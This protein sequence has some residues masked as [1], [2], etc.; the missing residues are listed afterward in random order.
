MTPTIAEIIWALGL[1]GW[2][3]IRYPHERRARKT[4][5]SQSRRGL[6]ETLLLSISTTGLAIIPGAYV[7]FGFD[8]FADRSFSPPIAWAGTVVFAASLYLFHLTHRDLGRNWSLSL[9]VRAQH[10]LV[11]EGIYARVRHPMYSA[12][13]LWAAAQALLLPNWIAGFAGLVGFG[14]LYM[15]RIE[16]EEAMMA[17]TFGQGYVD[18]ARRTKRLVPWIY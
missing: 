8:G 7:S 15:F 6:Y 16:R 3:V 1:V 11:T 10:R 2:Y 9:D 4:A 18:Y 13:F 14:T 17:E 12:F 5:V